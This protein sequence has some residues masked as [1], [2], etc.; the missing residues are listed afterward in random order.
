MERSVEAH[1]RPYLHPRPLRGGSRR[2]A[3]RHTSPKVPQAEIMRRDGTAQFFG[4]GSF[5]AHCDRRGT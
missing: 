5:L 3:T 1:G 4:L 2:I